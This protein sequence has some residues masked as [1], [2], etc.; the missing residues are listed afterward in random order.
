MKQYSRFITLTGGMLAFFSFALP[1]KHTYSGA[2]L[3]NGRGWP[4]TL[5][6]IGSSIVVGVGYYVLSQKSRDNPRLITLGLIMSGLG[7]LCW[8]VT[9]IQ[10]LESR[11]NFITISFVAS[12][13]IVGITIYTLNRQTP[14]KSIPTKLLLISSSVG[15]ICFFI[16]FFSGSLAIG[17]GNRVDN[18][19][20]GASLSAI[21]Y[22]LALVGLLCFPKSDEK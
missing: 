7:L 3:A 18:T 4:I 12:L 22:I 1:W 6:F 19:Q 11:I 5:A 21:G 10:F 20:Y 17:S 8:V 15:L 2:M 9:L 14:W 13:I 16:L